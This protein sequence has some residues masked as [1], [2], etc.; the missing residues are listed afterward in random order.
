MW[1]VT[2]RTVHPHPAVESCVLLEGALQSFEV[3]VPG[4]PVPQPDEHSTFTYGE[5]RLLNACF[6]NDRAYE[7]EYATFIVSTVD[8]LNVCMPRVDAPENLTQLPDT[9]LPLCPELIS[10]LVLISRHCAV[11][12]A[13]KH[14]KP[15]DQMNSEARCGT[16][17]TAGRAPQP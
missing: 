8:D 16:R 3:P 12:G 6:P 5:P 13:T 17:I 9:E 14:A 7:V 10:R 11:E 1:R 2:S 15:R 4:L